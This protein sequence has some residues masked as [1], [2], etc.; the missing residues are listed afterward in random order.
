[1]SHKIKPDGKF[2][3]VQGQVYMKKHSP[4]KLMIIASCLFAL[5]GFVSLLIRQ[6]VMGGMWIAIAGMF[7]VLSTTQPDK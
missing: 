1:L 5:S 7:L 2:G 6:W 3:L 4:R